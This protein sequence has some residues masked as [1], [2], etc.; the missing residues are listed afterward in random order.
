MY[1]FQSYF[2]DKPLV[3][4]RIFDVFEP[5]A[6]VPVKDVAIFFVHGGGWR[7]GS[8][9]G[10]YEIMEAFGKLGYITCTTDY[11]LNVNGF[12][13]L[14]DIRE[15]YDCFVDILKKRNHSCRIAGH[16]S[17]AGAHLASLLC[18]A[19]PGECGENIDKI[20][21]CDKNYAFEYSIRSLAPK[22][23]ITDELGC[24]SDWTCVLNA[25][26]CGVK[27]IASCHSDSV[28]SVTKKCWFNKNV[29]ERYVVLADKNSA[30]KIYDGDFNLL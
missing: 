26:S 12:E 8:R 28:E 2:L 25:V 18:C 27:I 30:H 24:Q 4:G 11:R 17:S 20:S 3:K 1:A 23:I 21:F 22:I 19:K 16:G 29:F 5:A 14:S 9:T 15:A 13:Q 7:A 6:G 10:F